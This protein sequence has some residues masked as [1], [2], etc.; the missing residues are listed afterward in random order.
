M[1]VM[2]TLNMN[3]VGDF[4]GLQG[5]LWTF[6][7]LHCQLLNSLF[8]LDAIIVS[9]SE[10]SRELS[11]LKIGKVRGPDQICLRLLREG[12]DVLS[13]SLTKLFNKSLTVGKLPQDW[14]SA[15]IT[16]VFKKG[17]KQQLVNY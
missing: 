3:F 12:A 10:V 5:L 7:E 14:V 1:V 17:D 8:H 9:P 6:R 13:L 16:P 4:Q 2:E 11:S 15:N